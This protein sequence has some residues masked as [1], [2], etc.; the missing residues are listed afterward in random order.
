[1]GVHGIGSYLSLKVL[2]LTIAPCA[3]LLFASLGAVGRCLAVICMLVSLNLVAAKSG[4]DVSPRHVLAGWLAAQWTIILL[5]FR[6]R[7]CPR[8]I[9][10]LSTRSGLPIPSGRSAGMSRVIV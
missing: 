9:E 2:I 10:G 7:P 8:L 5:L 6:M 1:M 4:S 3:I